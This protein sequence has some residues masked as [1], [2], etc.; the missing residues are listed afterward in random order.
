M[1]IGFTCGAFDLLHPGHVHFLAA[2]SNRCDSLVVGL[3]A[4]PQVDRVTKNAPVQTLYERWFQLSALSCV[5]RIIP[6]ETEADLENLLAIELLNVR[7]LGSDYTSQ[8][9]YTGK[10]VCE[11]RGIAIEFIPRLHTFSSSELRQRVWARQ[12]KQY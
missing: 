1:R 10:A 11:R 6:Y 12:W 4:N 2:C 5:T 8:Q 9:D 7:F 3:H